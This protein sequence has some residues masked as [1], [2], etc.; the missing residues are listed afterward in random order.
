MHKKVEDERNELKVFHAFR[1]EIR[2]SLYLGT[3]INR[4]FALAR[5]LVIL[6]QKLIGNC[7]R[8]GRL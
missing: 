1:H 3:G 7:G 4:V 2:S 8:L 6:L 5:T